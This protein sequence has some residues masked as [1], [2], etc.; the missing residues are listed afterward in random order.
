M[1]SDFYNDSP[2][3]TPDDDK[4]G[5]TPF[6]KSLAK[7][8]LGIKKPVGTAIA[9]NGAWGSG[10]SSAVNLI[11]AELGKEGDEQLVV[12]DF[13]CWWY[14][15]EEALALAFLQN[16]HALLSDTLKDKIKDLVPKL[17]KGLLQG[18]PVIGAAMSL[19]PAA[20]LGPIAITSSNF[21]KRYFPDGVTLEKNFQKLA[22]VLEEEERRFLIVIDDIDRLSTDETLAIFRIIK[23]IGHLPNV[24]YLLVFDRVLAEKVV[25][26]RYPSEG[27]H[28]LEKIIQASFELPSP[29]RTDLNNA[30][31]STIEAIC[32]SPNEKQLKRLLNIFHDIVVPYL[33]TPRHVTR[34]HNAISVSWPAIAGEISIADFIALEAIRLYEPS[35]FQA[36]R[37]NKENLCCGGNANDGDGLSFEEKFEVYLQGVG[38][39]RHE[40]VRIALQRLFP[41]VENVN[42]GD[43][44]R[45]NW[46]TERRVCIK[47]HFDTYFRMSLSDET[48]SIEFI[49]KLIDQAADQNFIQTTFREASTEKRRTGTSMVPVLLD[50]LNTHALRVV[51]E[52]VKPLITAL[53]E[54]HDE[55]DLEI[56]R[57]R[58]F[59]GMANTTLRYHWVIRRLTNDRF[60]IN[61]RTDIYI[62][63]IENAS[64]GWLVNFTNSARDDYRERD[65]GPQREEDCLIHENAV[66]PLVERALSAIRSAA[67]D[68][69]LLSHK[70]LIYI[71]YRWQSFLEDDPTEVRAW[72]DPLLSDDNALVVFARELTGE[73]WSQGL[74]FAGLGDRV[75]Q[76]S[77]RAQIDENMK[78]LDIGRFRVELERLQIS[79][80]LDKLS[81][82]T[83]DEFLEAWDRRIDGTDD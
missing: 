44:F 65:S 40:I 36:I 22:K 5:I 64:L 51:P 55:I 81:Q 72:T 17:G 68:G 23:S 60:T 58:G 37:S 18:G 53:F 43:G 47:A 6:S 3:E 20:V 35:L 45:D 57:D 14:R 50:E 76:R 52:K 19:T 38:Q 67:V 78:F 77:I 28:F 74:S 59:Y 66:A 32:G 80:K 48:L 56:D 69:S 54:I 61:E 25:T 49:N 27:P 39:N 82:K 29:L 1:S 42:Y 10:K 62:S 7:S 46:D 2:I 9:L 73:T 24:M 13:K 11:R 41:S 12:S 16:L 33:T 21:A 26:E 70:N 4:Y 34:F 15:G 30:I 75:A 63:S 79:R 71:L 83:V 8:I 31:L